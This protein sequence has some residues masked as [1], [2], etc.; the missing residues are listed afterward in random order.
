MPLSGYIVKDYEF[1]NMSTDMSSFLDARERLE[2]LAVVGGLLWISGIRHDILFA[3]LYL[4]WST[5]QP[6]NH[7]MKMAKYTLSYLFYSSELPL[8]LGGPDKFILNGYTNASLGTAPNGR[9]V[10]CLLIYLLDNIV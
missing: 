2:Y 5:K 6:R 1:D 7:H 8:V 4:T 10:I 9:S 3:V